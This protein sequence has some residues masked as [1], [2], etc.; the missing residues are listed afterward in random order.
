MTYS[1]FT[2][3]WNSGKRQSNKRVATKVLSEAGRS[4]QRIGLV[5]NQCEKAVK[6]DVADPTTKQKP[7]IPG[8]TKATSQMKLRRVEF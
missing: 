7:Q 4:E 3:H 2:N 5:L 8:Q 6:E 1:F